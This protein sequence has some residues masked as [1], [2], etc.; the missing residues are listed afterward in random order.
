MATPELYIASEGDI[1]EVGA[2]LRQNL[3]AFNETFIGPHKALHISIGAKVDG[4]IVGAVAG[5]VFLDWLSIELVF[6]QER[7]RGQGLGRELLEKI[8]QEGRRLGAK[9]AFVDTTSFQAEGFY[10]KFGYQEWGRFRDF[11]PGTDRI[12]LRKDAL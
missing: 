3:H 5:V 4:Q 1:T 6:L 2:W 10:T 7:Y 9:R 8:E 11:T 12:Y